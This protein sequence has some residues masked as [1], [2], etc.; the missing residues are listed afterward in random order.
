MGGGS[1]LIAWMAVLWVLERAFGLSLFA[2]G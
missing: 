2:R 1:L